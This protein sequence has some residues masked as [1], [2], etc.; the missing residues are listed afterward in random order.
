MICLGI[1]VLG[2]CHREDLPP[3]DFNKKGYWEL[4]SKEFMYGI[5]SNK[6]QGTAVK[7]YGSALFM[8]EKSLISKVII[9]RRNKSDTINSTLKMLIADGDRFGFPK[10]ESFANKVYEMNYTLLEKYLYLPPYIPYIEVHYETITTQPEEQIKE[11][12]SFLNIDNE[13]KIQSA[14]N[15]IEVKICQ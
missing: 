8:T 12:A 3:L 9:C 15:N 6:Y 5:T 2:D 1:P 10:T 13:E 7:L 4:P 14:T 11:I